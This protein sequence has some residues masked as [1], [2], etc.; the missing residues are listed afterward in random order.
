[1]TAFMSRHSL[2]PGLVALLL[3]CLAAPGLSASEHH[4]VVES[5]GLPVPGATVSAIQGDKKVVTTTDDQGAYSFP[6]LAD[7]VWTIEVDMFGF[8]KLS[9][10]VGIAPEAP[11][12][13]WQLQVL[14]LSALNT[15]APAPARTPPITPPAGTPPPRRGGFAR[16]GAGPRQGEG[17]PGGPVSLRQA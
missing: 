5:N 7:G 15:P 2:F 6:N 4:G 11:S 16:G 9:R 10:E 3:A 13:T 8:A 17:G 14:P 12:P 1:M